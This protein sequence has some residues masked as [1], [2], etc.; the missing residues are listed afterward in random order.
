MFN[1][2]FSKRIIICTITIMYITIFS[3]VLF[4]QLTCSTAKFLSF[5]VFMPIVTVLLFILSCH[6]KKNQIFLRKHRIVLFISALSIM[7]AILL[8]FGFNNMQECID[9]NGN[10]H[11][12][13]G[14]IM[15]S[16]ESLA[17]SGEIETEYFARY[18]NNLFLLILFGSIAKLVQLFTG[19]VELFYYVMVVL[20]CMIITLGVMFIVLSVNK[21]N[22]TAGGIIAFATCFFFAPLYLISATPYSDTLAFFIVSAM[23][24]MVILQMQSKK[25]RYAIIFGVLAAFGSSLKITVAI[26]AIAYFLVLLFTSNRI[27]DCLKA[28]ASI[29]VSFSLIFSLISF[30]VNSS[31]LVSEEDKDM[32]KF[33]VTHWIMMS[34]QGE[35]SYNQEDVDF[36]ASAGNYEA[37]NEAAIAEIK[38][39]I[40]SMGTGGTLRHIFIVKNRSTWCSGTLGTLFMLQFTSP[41]S[42]FNKLIIQHSFIY[43]GVAAYAY[44]FFTALTTLALAGAIIGF[45]RHSQIISVMRLTLIGAFLFFLIWET[46]TTYVF[47]FSPIII[48]LATNSLLY[49]K[50][51][52]KKT[53]R[54]Q[55]QQR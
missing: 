42:L 43:N 9:A 8:F 29:V 7:F 6:V 4:I 5:V 39:R 19:S 34:L 17:I 28:C 49:I 12:D 27:R 10:A 35:G 25:T 33:P 3:F 38:N 18:T 31:G 26:L 46:K 45:K 53:I 55:K 21:L 1:K 16:A 22:G 47:Q 54:K 40:E 50:N 20:N 11:W 48:I 37:K 15:R 41:E 30:G 2:I 24:Y 23:A 51:A 52:L 44:G 36:T 32:Y 14:N 13:L